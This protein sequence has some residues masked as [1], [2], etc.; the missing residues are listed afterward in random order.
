MTITTRLTDYDNKNSLV[1]VLRAKRIEPFLKMIENLHR[2]NGKVRI[3]D[4]G[5]TLQYWSIVPQKF[6]E[7]YSVSIFIANISE[8][9]SFINNE[10]FF[11]IIADG[12][13]LG[14]FDNNSFDIVHSNSVLEHVGDWQRKV[15][16][17]HEIRRI[18]KNYFV[19]TPNYWFPIEPHCRMPFFHWFP[20]PFRVFLIM[21]FNLG[22]W[23]RAKDVDK[24][25]RT[26]ESA[27]LVTKMMLQWL[28]PDSQINT[29]RFLILPKSYIAICDNTHLKAH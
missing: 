16:F 24:A 14:I 5:G 12:C 3:L 11:S 25:I 20:K 10:Q 23:E 13:D 28:F 18:A 19:Q 4:V 7:R 1:S 9:D 15:N 22:Y 27:R 21:H 2:K 8:N 26:V 6:L 17:A 29:E